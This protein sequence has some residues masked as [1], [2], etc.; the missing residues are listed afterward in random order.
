[1]RAIAFVVASCAAAVAVAAPVTFVENWD[2]YP[3]NT[4]PTAPWTT[5]AS[6]N[7]ASLGLP[8]YA[9]YS[10]SA[11]HSLLVNNSGYASQEKGLMAPLAGGQQV[12]A[13]ND[14]PLT[15]SY[16]V[17]PHVAAQ[18]KNSDFFVEISFGDVH[19][20]SNLS[21]VLST[22][23]PVL[24]FAHPIGAADS[25]YFWYFDGTQWL[26]PG[27]SMNTAA[28]NLVSM[29]VDK[30]SALL[31]GPNAGSLD[32]P[33]AYQGRFDSISV[34][35]RDFTYTS[36]TEIDDVSVTG[37]YIVPEPASVGLLLAAL[38]LLLRR[39]AR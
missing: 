35:T 7:S 28:W 33:R 31:S 11:P 14:F 27:A 29:V 1:M 2:S 37:G 21:T 16:Q 36:H 9:T 18:R 19:A 32:L 38:P 39:R 17:R 23:I 20:P 30:D 4:V 15:M 25:T 10:V 26:R 34:Y 22:P 13:T 24:A 3:N 12:Q 5:P 8:T 6:L